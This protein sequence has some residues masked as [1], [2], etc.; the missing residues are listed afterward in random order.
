ML[1]RNNT[2]RN[3]RF[4]EY[5]CNDDDEDIT[6]KKRL[7]TRYGHCHSILSCNIELCQCSAYSFFIFFFIAS[8][9][10]C[11]TLKR[12]KLPEELV[13]RILKTEL[14]FLPC[15]SPVPCSFLKFS[16]ISLILKFC[17]STAP[18]PLFEPHMPPFENSGV[19]KSPVFSSLGLVWC[20]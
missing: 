2:A 1:A 3:P 20:L 8:A 14:G 5:D 13:S 4:E 18:A 11:E 16:A 7:K 9:G 6:M 10:G 17:T 15:F 19:L 12:A